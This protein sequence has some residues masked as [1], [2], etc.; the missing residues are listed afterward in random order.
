MVKTKELLPPN[1]QGDKNIE[2]LCAAA[3]K[4]FS[5]EDSL[6][7]LLV[8]VIDSVPDVL[9]FLAWQFHVEGWEFTQTDAERRAL[10]KNSVLL[11]RHKGTVWAIEKVFE[12]LNLDAEVQE[13]FQYEGD[14]Y[15]FKVFL[16]SVVQDED[17]YIKLV[18]L[19]NSYKNVRSWL[20]SIGIHREHTNGLHLGMLIQDGK[21]YTIGLHVEAGIDAAAVY[22][23]LVQRAAVS[24]TISVH[25]PTIDAEHISGFVTG[26]VRQAQYTII[27]GA[28][29]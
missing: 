1:L 5:L 14:P 23:A 29:G 6:D 13:W 7:V 19:I 26:F 20:D 9:P 10:I 18:A 15:K 11:H 24:T 28:H 2:G 22:P 25:N 17:T 16:K 8:Y 27:G 21:F 3:D 12:I 4:V